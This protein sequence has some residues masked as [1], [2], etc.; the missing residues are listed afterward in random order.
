MAYEALKTLIRQYIKPN[1]QEEITGAILQGILLEMVNQLGVAGNYLPLT[2][3]N[4]TG[5]VIVSSNPTATTHNAVRLAQSGVTIENIASVGLNEILGLSA[6]SITYQS[7]FPNATPSTMAVS[8]GMTGITMTGGITASSFVNS[9]VEQS[10]RGNYLLKAD[11]NVVSISDIGGGVD[12]SVVWESLA[13]DTNE[14]IASSHLTTALSAYATITQLGNYLRLTGGT[15]TGGLNISD[16]SHGYAQLFVDEDGLNIMTGSLTGTQQLYTGRIYSDS[17]IEA[18][19]SITGFSFIKNG[20]T[21]AQFLKADGSVDSNTYLTSASLAGYLPLT[22]GTVSG[23][24]TVNEGISTRSLNAYTISASR[25]DIAGSGVATQSWVTTQLGNYLPLTGGT[26]SGN[27][28]VSNAYM[29]V[30]TAGSS[31]TSYTATITGSGIEAQML[32]SGTPINSRMVLNYGGLTFYD[33]NVAGTTI[34]LSSVTSGSFI[35]SGGT[36]AQFLKADGSVDSNTY[37]TLASVK[38]NLS[39]WNNTAMTWG[40]LTAANGYTIGV[41]ASSSDGGDW[42][43]CYKSGQISMQLD[44]WYYQNEGRYRVV[45]TSDLA[46]YN[47]TTNFKTINN[48]SIIGTGNINIEGGGGGGTLYDAEIEYIE[49]STGTEVIDTGIKGNNNTSVYI[50][51]SFSD[52]TSKDTLGIAANFW[53]AT[54]YGFTYNK[55]QN[56]LYTNVQ[57]GYM[58]RSINLSTN[59]QHEIEL[60]CTGTNATSYVNGSQMSTKT[61]SS[62]TTLDTIKTN[63]NVTNTRIYAIKIWENNVLV[64][65]MIPVRVG[66]VGYMYDKVS[67]QLFGNAGSGNFVL[68]QDTGP[69]GGSSYLPITGGTITGNLTV[70][71]S[72]QIDG[73][74]VVNNF[75]RIS[76]GDFCIWCPQN[77]TRLPKCLFVIDNITWSRIEMDTVGAFHF[78]QADSG[79][80]TYRPIYAASFNQGSDLR[81]KNIIGDVPINLY[82]VANAPLFKFTWNNETKYSG[83]HIGSA[84][85]YWQTVLPELVSIG[86]DADMTLAMQYDVIALASAITVAKKVVDHEERIILL[87]RENEALKKEIANLK[88]A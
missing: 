2:G 26:L 45:D 10:V 76:T 53:D 29:S 81:K 22:G 1:E 62:F 85:Q 12:M 82:N 31:A 8:F 21:S 4:I 3:G 78:R 86:R 71:G 34:T 77:Y 6:N 80:N 40:T 43:M 83:Q 35:K 67:G 50:K 73:E 55:G 30:V 57:S 25:I 65:D 20:G 63:I 70:G 72:T 41:H 37:I 58:E 54:P 51:C 84:A 88:S 24:I 33:Q 17:T 18:T 56:N 11:G 39:V 7:Y 68:G 61:I 49:T 47:P 42:G 38:G 36:S 52:T 16:G 27:L 48:Q 15:L 44:G 23:S 5:N 9:S 74:L 28:T 69:G 64:R 14:Q 87:E 46:S 32:R 19:G 13:D 66:Q 79:T 59:T 60:R 75:T